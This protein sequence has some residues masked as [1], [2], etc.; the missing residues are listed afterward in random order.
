MKPALTIM[1]GEVGGARWEASFRHSIG[2]GKT[3]SGMCA[4]VRPW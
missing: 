4:K 2:R 3:C 1:D